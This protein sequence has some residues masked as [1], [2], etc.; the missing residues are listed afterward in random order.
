MAKAQGVSKAT[1]ARLTRDA[2]AAGRHVKNASTGDSFQNFAARVGI[3]TNNLSTDSSYGFNPIS[4][5][6]TL[7]E[8][9]Y[10]GSWVVGRVVDSI[11]EDM[12]K[13]GVE[14]LGESSPDSISKLNRGFVKHTIWKRTSDALKWARL[15]GGAIAYL[16]IDGQ[17]PTTPL[18]LDTIAPGQFKGIIVFDRWMVTPS[19]E[20]LVTDMSSPALG[21][22]KFYTVV[23]AA[24]GYPR[25]QMHHSRCLR[26]VGVELPFWQ[27]ISENMWGMSVLERLYDRLVAF[28]SG[29]QGASQLLYK[30]YL[31][32]LQIPQLR[33][34]IA[35]GGPAYEAMLQQ[36]ALMR[37]MQSNEGMSIID[38]ED[39]F[40][41]HQYSF[42][43]I[44]DTLLQF[45]QQLCGAAET[46]YT[47]LFGQSPAGMDATGESD[48]RN[49]YDNVQQRQETQ[50]RGFIDITSRVIARSEGIQLDPSF[51]FKFN[52]L[53][54]IT[55]NERAEIGERTTNSVLAAEGAGIIDLPTAMAEL[56]Q[57]S[58][59]TGLFTNITDEMIEAAKLA[60][61]PGV[62]SILDQFL[63]TPA[64]APGASAGP[65][66]PPQ[67]G[68][69]PEPS[70]KAPPP[71]ARDS[72]HLPLVEV[73]GIPT[74]IETHAGERRQGNGW[75]AQMPADYGFFRATSSAEGENEGMDCF[76]GLD[77]QSRDV[78]VIDQVDP[79]TGVF[80]EHKV[81]LGF[82]SSKDALDCYAQAY[83][84]GGRGRIAS[85]T[86][87]DVEALKTWLESGDHKNPLGKRRLTR[88]LRAE[89]HLRA[90]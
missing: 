62:D 68:E 45:A 20:D 29:T 53:W 76:L 32:T 82:L 63:G 41:G 57:A 64:P 34:I 51:D 75:A 55:D 3:G 6:Q 8:W 7:M 83:H 44:G 58:K 27:R 72:A 26:L 4:R 60:P 17:N 80:D 81:M 65:D 11:A 15:Y 22:P 47:R 90:V 61:D 84:D 35:A 49:Y 78:W 12:T 31:R 21:L 42:A 89:P 86:H 36:V 85:V 2:K 88:D 66:K 37:T 46:P 43:G 18:R 40:E 74:M 70:G 5:I 56:K 16:N 73:H 33:E 52:P 79:K 23:T 38:G 1:E 59:T 39:K 48:L 50:L 77:R 87:M 28:D 71:F 24:A 30:A 54:Q 67:P 10:R 14:F 69:K 19:L 9:M 25:I 13:N